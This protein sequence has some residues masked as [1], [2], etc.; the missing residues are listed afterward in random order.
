LNRSG[1]VAPAGS[2]VATKGLAL[3]LLSCTSE[4]VA[5][6]RAIA[7]PI[8]AIGQVGKPRLLHAFSGTDLAALPAIRIIF[9]ITVPTDA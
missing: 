1:S 5:S 2:H 4:L 9:L 3:Y 7:V 8:L 6:T